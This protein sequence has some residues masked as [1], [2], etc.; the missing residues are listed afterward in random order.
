MSTLRGRTLATAETLARN[1]PVPMFLPTGHVPH[2]E[3]AATAVVTNLRVVQPAGD[4]Q[5]E[6]SRQDRRRG[7]L[8]YLGAYTLGLVG[9]AYVGYRVV[10][11][12]CRET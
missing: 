12:L 10:D 5:T 6:A 1:S 11:K 4:A 2:T 8:V 3:P 9:A 7:M